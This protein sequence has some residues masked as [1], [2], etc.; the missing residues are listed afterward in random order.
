[1]LSFLMVFRSLFQ[2]LRRGWHDPQFRGLLYLT[3]GL[4]LAGTFFYHRVEGWKLF[5]SLYFSVVTLAT[6]GYGDFSPQ[7]AAGRVF[8]IFYIL[9]GLGILVGL[10]TQIA[11]HAA[12]ARA[13]RLSSR[14][15]GAGPKSRP[16]AG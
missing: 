12:A 14:H 16:A 3:L 7:T 13:D 8:T 1:M 5:E 15:R 2:A 9:I 4:L 11:T 10:A 6:V